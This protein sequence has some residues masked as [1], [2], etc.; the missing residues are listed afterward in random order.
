ML[1][2][3]LYHNKLALLSMERKELVNQMAMLEQEEQHPAEHVVT[4][5]DLSTC[6]KDNVDEKHQTHYRVARVLHRGVS[7]A[8]A[9]AAAASHNALL[10][11]AYHHLLCP[12]LIK[13]NGYIL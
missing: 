11:V 8:A 7:H 6:L 10:A 5:S 12:I 9:A 2:R 1:L 4:G 3:Q 13:V